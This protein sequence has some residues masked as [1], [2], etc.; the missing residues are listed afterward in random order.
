M[1]NLDRK[2]ADRRGVEAF[3][4]YIEDN[5]FLIVSKK[6]ISLLWK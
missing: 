4:N 2:E 5:F 6:Q 1:Q 3:E